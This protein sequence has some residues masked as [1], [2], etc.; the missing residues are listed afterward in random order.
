MLKKAHDPRITPWIKPALDEQEE[1]PAYREKFGFTRL[2]TLNFACRTWLFPN[3]T[4]ANLADVL[5]VTI[6]ELRDIELGNKALSE[7]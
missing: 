1:S 6:E 4:M 3:G 7:G 5:G 2:G